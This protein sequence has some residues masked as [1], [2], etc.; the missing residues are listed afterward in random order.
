M[1]S[2]DDD[3]GMMGRERNLGYVEDVILFKLADVVWRK[4]FAFFV[5]T[6]M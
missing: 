1:I 5:D 4:V 6:G 3:G 2:G